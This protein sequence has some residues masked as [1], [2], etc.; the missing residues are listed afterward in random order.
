MK[1][2]FWTLTL[3]IISIMGVIVSSYLEYASRQPVCKIGVGE[4]DK[5]ITS[6]YSKIYGIPLST[7]GLAWFLTLLF[8]TIVVSY[9]HGK[10]A[11]YL[12]LVWALMSVPSVAALLW[13]ELAILNT[14]CM[15][16]TIAHILGVVSI[17][18]A[19]KISRIR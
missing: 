12:V 4:C 9:K 15:Y 2:T 10:A 8:L 17:I 18:P 3:I 7:L 1:K 19:Y 13:I 14:I 16:C 5:V 6:P 11:S